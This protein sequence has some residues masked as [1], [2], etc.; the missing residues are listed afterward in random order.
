MSMNFLLWINK[1]IN[2]HI[3]IYVQKIEDWDSNYKLLIKTQVFS[4]NNFWEI[5]DNWNF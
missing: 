1:F 4:A 2:I 3:L 5:S